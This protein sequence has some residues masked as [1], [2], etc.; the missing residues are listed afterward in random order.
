[1]IVRYVLVL[2]D[3]VAIVF[4]IIACDKV[5][6]SSATGV[7]RPY[8]TAV[9]DTITAHSCCRRHL[10]VCNPTSEPGKLG[11]SCLFKD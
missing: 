4:P 2:E 7:L 8:A 9:T 11:S 5:D 10:A 1:M 3:G 6:I